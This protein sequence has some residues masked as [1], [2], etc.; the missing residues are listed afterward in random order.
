[1]TL[2]AAINSP[3]LVIPVLNSIVVA[4]RRPLQLV[5]QL[6]V[7]FSLKRDRGE[8]SLVSNL[9]LNPSGPVVI[10]LPGLGAEV[11]DH[12]ADA[13]LKCGHDSAQAPEL[14]DHAGQLITRDAADGLQILC[15]MANVVSADGRAGTIHHIV[16]KGEKDIGSCQKANTHNEKSHRRGSHQPA[17][18]IPSCQT[19]HLG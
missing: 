6:F 8:R 18:G 16:V 3:F 17:P 5:G 14:Q 11:T 10:H 19:F 9:I 13:V 7:L 12:F 1:M 15:L 2:S 4:E